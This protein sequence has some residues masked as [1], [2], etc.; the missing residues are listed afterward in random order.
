MQ[1][2]PGTYYL[3][4]S[5]QSCAAVL[6]YSTESLSILDP[7][8][9]VLWQGNDFTTGADLPGL[10]LEV[11]LVDGSY[12][13]PDDPK[14]RLNQ[15]QKAG[16]ATRLEQHK[17]IIVLS[18]LLVPV[19]LWWISMV[20]IPKMAVAIVPWVPPTAIAA[21]DQQTLL[22]LD[23]TMLNPSELTADTQQYWREQWLQA[24]TSLPQQQQRV[25][26]IQFRQ[27][28][29]LGPNAFALPA[30]TV[31]F[32]DELVSLL[33][34]KPDALL[35]VFLHEVGHV[36][37]QHGMT[38][39]VQ[40]TATSLVFAMLFTDLEGITEVLLGTGS[41]LLQAS[42]SRQMESQADDFATDH[43]KALGKSSSGF[44]DAMQAISSASG[45]KNAEELEQ[46]MQYLSSHPSSVERIEKAKTKQ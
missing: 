46:W 26:D 37:H 16:L 3:A 10:P 44:I 27:A 36:Q 4:A 9:A 41:S 13:L 24:L 31:V 32:T 35:A 18:V 14:A 43:L 33:K 39:L 21:V 30:G 42:F 20:G 22:M 23:K 6:H 7:A 15:F 19:L 1:S 12:F 8:G 5:S 25:I 45:G 17:T 11:R 40:S 2:I 34:D 29:H 38:L 28:K